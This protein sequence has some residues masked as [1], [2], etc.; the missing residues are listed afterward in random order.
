MYFHD[1]S[2]TVINENSQSIGSREKLSQG[3]SES[4]QPAWFCDIW[5]QIIYVKFSLLFN[6]FKY[7]CIGSSLVDRTDEK[8]ILTSLPDVL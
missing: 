4:N 3:F 1:S 2:R 5:N 8:L 7:S 6:L